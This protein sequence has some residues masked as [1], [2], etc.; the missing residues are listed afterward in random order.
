MPTGQRPQVVTIDEGDGPVKVVK[1]RARQR[2]SDLPIL[3]ASL[4]KTRRMTGWRTEIP[5]AQTLE[6]TLEYWRT[7]DD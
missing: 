5:L 6:D 4:A 2:P 1:D 7:H 3:A